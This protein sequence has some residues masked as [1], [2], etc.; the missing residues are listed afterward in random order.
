MVAQHEAEAAAEVAAHLHS[1]VGGLRTELQVRVCVF[2]CAVQ[3]CVCVFVNGSESECEHVCACVTCVCA[4]IVWVRVHVLVTALCL[5]ALAD[6][7]LRVTCTRCVLLEHVL[8]SLD[9]K[10]HFSIVASKPASHV[11]RRPCA[12]PAMAGTTAMRHSSQA[13]L[14]PCVPPATCPSRHQ[15]FAH[16][17]GCVASHVSCQSSH[18]PRETTHSCKSPCRTNILAAYFLSRL[19]TQGCSSSCCLKRPRKR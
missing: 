16:G 11:P 19:Q 2:V 14:Q 10:A 5:C 17:L 15:Q 4:L 1:D 9:Q 18:G 8:C 3:V 6:L 12:F 13:P 7:P